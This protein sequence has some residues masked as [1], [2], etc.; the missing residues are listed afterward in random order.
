MWN[1]EIKDDIGD[2]FARRQ[3]K[4]RVG[5]GKIDVFFICSSCFLASATDVTLRDDNFKH[6]WRV[7]QF[8]RKS[9]A[10]TLI[11][12]SGFRLHARCA[13]P[14]TGASRT[15]I[16]CTCARALWAAE[17]RKFSNC[18]RLNVYRGTECKIFMLYIYVY[19]T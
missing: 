17:L 12:K 5:G 14:R 2:L 19:V 18:R 13:M 8:R 3:A 7:V 6:R 9:L 1:R 15:I 10:V 11:G 16:N 4:R